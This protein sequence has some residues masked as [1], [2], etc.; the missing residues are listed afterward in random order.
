MFCHQLRRSARRFLGTAWDTL[1]QGGQIVDSLQLAEV[2]AMTLGNHEFDY[3]VT[4]V[5]IPAGNR[6]RMATGV[7]CAAHTCTG[8]SGTDLTSGPL[9]IPIRQVPR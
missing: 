6:D 3:G 8:S 2:D 7:V 1:F 5:T 4:F 9:S